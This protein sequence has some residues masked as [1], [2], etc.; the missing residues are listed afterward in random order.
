MARTPFSS[1]SPFAMISKPVLHPYTLELRKQIDRHHSEVRGRNGISDQSRLA[2]ARIEAIIAGDIPTME[3]HKALCR[4]FSGMKH[5]HN[6]L[7][8]WQKQDSKDT[9]IEIEV[10]D[11]PM[12]VE[13]PIERPSRVLVVDPPAPLVL[14]SAP[15]SKPALVK[16]DPPKVSRPSISPRTFGEWLRA[17]REEEK[18]DQRDVASMIGVVPNAV[19]AWENDDTTPVRENYEKLLK[20]FDKLK[21]APKP[22]TKVRD[23]AVPKGALGFHRPS[24]PESVP[25]SKPVTIASVEPPAEPIRSSVEPVKSI[26]PQKSLIKFGIEL[27]KLRTLDLETRKRIVAVVALGSSAGVSLDEVL[28][29]LIDEEG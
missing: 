3:E 1:T 9:R 10:V 29:M 5:Q 8:L 7:V 27:N 21:D 15:A 26:S 13:R 18:L 6:A 28:A 12:K 14:A 22:R 17:C 2:P 19:G 16:A 23:I 20:I 25:E 11:T 4:M 24:Q